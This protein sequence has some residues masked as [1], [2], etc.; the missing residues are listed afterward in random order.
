M[1]LSI[2]DD[3]ADRLARELASLTGESLTQAITNSLRER[4]ARLAPKRSASLLEDI[5]R[6]GLRNANRP[7]LDLRPAEEILG[8]DEFGLPT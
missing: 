1:A 8:Y 4:L 7:L 6:I 3:E 2:K 5:E